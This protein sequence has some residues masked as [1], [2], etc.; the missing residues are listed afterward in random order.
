MALTIRPRIPQQGGGSVND[1]SKDFMIN[2][3]KS[4]LHHLGNEPRLTATLKFV[5]NDDDHDLVITIARLLLQNKQAKTRNAGCQPS[6]LKNIG[7]I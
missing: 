2:H 1:H 3:T 7:N 6:F 4:G 5:H